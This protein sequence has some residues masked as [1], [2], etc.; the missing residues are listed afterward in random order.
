MTDWKKVLTDI[1]NQFNADFGM[2]HY[3]NPKDNCLHAIAFTENIPAHLVTA[4]NT[5]PVGKGIAGTTAM[6]KKPVA[7]KNLSAETPAFVQ[8]PAKVASLG[9]MMCVPI[10]HSGD[11]NEVVGTI[12]IGCFI[13]R[14]FTDDEINKMKKIIHKYSKELEQETAKAK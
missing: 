3:L 10:F 1:L 5:I 8:A 7:I 4:T 12:S 14:Q 11:D 13:E 6:T 2:L 9:G